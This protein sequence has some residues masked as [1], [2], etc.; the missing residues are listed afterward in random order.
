MKFGD[1]YEQPKV[2]KIK[3]INFIK[4][5]NEDKLKFDQIRKQISEVEFFHTILES[6]QTVRVPLV[7]TI[8]GENV[9]PPVQPDNAD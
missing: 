8:G 2:I 7:G 9:Q 4:V 6:Y 5:L 3:D 1:I